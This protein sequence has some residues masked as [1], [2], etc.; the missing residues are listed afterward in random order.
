MK[1]LDKENGELLNE[2]RGHVSKDYKIKCDIAHDDSVVFSGSEDGIIY[3]WDLVEARL[4]A[5]LKG[6]TKVVSGV[7]HHPQGHCLL[8]C[9]VDGTVRVW[10]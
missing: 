1:L 2:Y 9:S 5:K 4:L 7:D 3:C 8:S 6:H 10:K